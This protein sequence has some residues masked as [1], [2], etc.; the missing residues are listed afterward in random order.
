[1][2][3]TELHILTQYTVFWFLRLGWKAAFAEATDP[4]TN[5]MACHCR[6]ASFATP[7]K[8]ELDELQI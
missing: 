4:T 2:H 1:M 6:D 8:P 7:Q 3:K 5:L